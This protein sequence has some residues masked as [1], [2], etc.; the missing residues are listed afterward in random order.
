MLVRILPSA[1]GMLSHLASTNHL[2]TV[3]R[4]I[5][6][7]SK[8]DPSLPPLRLYT[9]HSAYV[10]V[11]IASSLGKH[12][13]NISQDVEW[14]P[15]NENMFGSVSDDGQIMMWVLIKTCFKNYQD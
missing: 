14:H 2:F 12:T 5:Q 13:S 9:G 1:T 4:D 15:K 6:G 11:S 10:A 8:Q 7:Y 3:P